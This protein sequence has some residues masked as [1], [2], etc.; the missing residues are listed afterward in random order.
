[1]NEKRRWRWIAL[2]VAWASFVVRG[3]FYCSVIPLWEGWDEYAYFASVQHLALRHTLPR[4]AET[5][6]EEVDRSLRL[7]P[8]SRAVVRENPGLLS[9]D[10][11]W[12]LPAAER[13]RREAQLRRLDPELG[14]IA[15]ASGPRQ[16]EAQQP[17]LAFGVLAPVYWLVRGQPLLVR[18][19]VLRVFDVLIAALSIPLAYAIVLQILKSA[20]WALAAAALVGSFPEFLLSASRVTNEPLASLLGGLV[21]LLTLRFL[22]KPAPRW[23]DAALLGLALGLAVMSKAYLLSLVPAVALVLALPLKDRPARARTAQVGLVL[24]GAAVVAGWWCWRNWVTTGTV[25]GVGIDAA[26]QALGGGG[27]LAAAAKMSWWRVVDGMIVTHAWC[28]NWSFLQVRSWMYRL[29]TAGALSILAALVVEVVRN[30]Q[31]RRGAL[32]AAVFL[33]AV[34]GALLYH[35]VILYRLTGETFG[36][37]WYLYGMVAA[38]AAL[39]AIGFRALARLRGGWLAAPAAVTALTLLDWFGAHALMLPYYAGL[40]RRDASGTVRAFDLR[41][42][43]WETVQ[44][45]SANLAMNKPAFLTPEVIRCLWIASL[46]AALATIAVVIAVAR[47]KDDV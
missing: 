17:P 29:Y 19:W 11:W 36:I 41:T 15:A 4:P 39:A 34:T 9:H 14:K 8:V 6:S 31:T 16:Y 5:N 2:G 33:A 12:Q 26:A 27:L 43:G 20:K 44:R 46:L 37:A 22:E 25:S 28:A 24:A 30:K 42:A 38:E 10:A 13:S 40:T 32:V 18:V 21:L 23:R 45:M 35:S 1:M 7:A 3:M 47:R